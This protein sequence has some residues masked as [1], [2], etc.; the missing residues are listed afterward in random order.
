MKNT[1]GLRNTGGLGSSRYG[2]RVGGSLHKTKT[3]K[4]V[5]R[6]TKLRA[7]RRNEWIKDHPPKEMPN[8][9]KFYMCHIC[10]Y[11]KEKPSVALVYFENFVLEHV[12]NKGHMS[13]EESQDDSNLAPAH[14][15]CNIRK[16]SAELWQMKQSPKTGK[17]NPH[18]D[19]RT[20][21][22]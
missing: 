20:I 9:R 19:V 1:G 6:I 22:K 18:T 4:K 11:F 5:G 16:G 12:E 7:E 21:S 8:G 14:S 13:F 3:I 10:V 17:P 2:L 15:L